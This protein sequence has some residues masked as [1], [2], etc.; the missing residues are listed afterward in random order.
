MLHS[1][2]T[3][4]A[5]S[6]AT[7]RLA[8]VWA[9]AAALQPALL[10]Q[11]ARGLAQVADAD[12]AIASYGAGARL[13]LVGAVPIEPAK[14]QQLASELAEQQHW[15]AVVVAK[16]GNA[17]S[18]ALGDPL[19]D[20]K[21]RLGKD[22]RAKTS[23]GRDSFDS[24][25]LISLEPKRV[26]LSLGKGYDDAGLSEGDMSLY[27]AARRALRDGQRIDD[28]IRD[29]VAAIDR[30]LAAAQ[31]F[32]WLI[33]GGAAL[34]FAGITGAAA[35]ARRRKRRRAI[36]R[37]EDWSKVLGEQQGALIELKRWGEILSKNPRYRGKTKEL[38]DS[39]VTDVQHIALIR[40]GI[41]EALDQAREL[42]YPKGSARILNAVTGWRYDKALEVMSRAKVRF[43]ADGDLARALRGEAIATGELQSIWDGAREV[44]REARSFDELIAEQG[45]RATRVDEV[46]KRIQKSTQVIQASIEVLRA[47]IDRFAS[48]LREFET[49]TANDPRCHVAAPRA[50]L[51]PSFEADYERTRA[52]A[53]PDPVLAMEGS[54]RAEQRIQKSEEVLEDLVQVVHDALPRLAEGVTAI[55][56][57]G[58]E[59]AWI[60]RRV[61]SVF[62]ACDARFVALSDSEVDI[63]AL[64]QL[65]IFDAISETFDE[66]GRAL[67]IARSRRD[68]GLP[69]L[70]NLRAELANERHLIA[71]KLGIEASQVLRERDADP[72]AYLTR[73]SEKLA[74]S[75]EA[76]GNGEVDEAFALVSGAHRETETARRILDDTRAALA[77]FEER[78]RA[79][80]AQLQ[81]VAGEDIASARPILASLQVYADAALRRD[82][83]EAESSLRTNITEASDHI[84]TATTH[85]EQAR[86]RHREARLLEADHDLDRAASFVELA[87]LRLREL[88]ERRTALTH[89]EDE[90]DR[91]AQTLRALV[92]DV[93]AARSDPAVARPTISKIDEAIA[94]FAA[95]AERKAS[96]RDPFARARELEAAR[97]LLHAARS[98]IDADHTMRAEARRSVELARELLRQARSRA[99]DAR[100]DAIPDS[101]R[102]EEAQRRLPE[103]ADR[104]D[105]LAAKLVEP[106]QDWVD[107]DA[108]ID[109]LHAEVFDL[110]ATLQREIEAGRIAMRDIE[111]AGDAV[112]DAAS[113]TETSFGHRLPGSPGRAAH[114]R[115]KELLER[116]RYAEASNMAQAAVDEARNAIAMAERSRASVPSRSTRGGFPFGR[117]GGIDVEGMVRDIFRQA[118]TEWSGH[119]RYRG[120]LELPRNVDFGTRS[121]HQPSAPAPS[122]RPSAPQRAPAD[123][124]DDSGFG[125][126]VEW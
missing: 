65:R 63:A 66:I 32:P 27:E 79:L 80:S 84:T 67:E 112:R 23:F 122:P 103:L 59:T 61:R 42:I 77:R 38:A 108:R 93:V 30:R 49:L 118:T 8:L 4:C 20:W 11:E 1:R 19:E 16:A 113:Y 36:V 57:H 99:E 15:V 90:N 55:S 91:N 114:V 69:A 82:G 81:S 51:L 60:D 107:L 62:E 78:S 75:V 33:G 96:D 126:S 13:I 117:G 85:V 98:G 39:I 6:N 86:A 125:P 83:G 92:Q 106:H 124:R 44:R 34:G 105:D 50:R 68:V 14:A 115:A 37:Y 119:R 9:L 48:A 53:L 70:D 2:C 110:E 64:Q 120:P 88:S 97:A 46:V 109:A 25:L 21:Q 41:L 89:K 45:S 76:L 40:G 116:G 100:R 10:A 74:T 18:A 56:G 94:T 71:E 29:T 43:D 102:I 31:R 73:A 35:M 22:L 87:R 111:R 58:I 5:G 28:A 104:L 47:R 24:I 95:V 7:V 3:A 54:S 17:L 26:A 12:A 72:D 121:R 52:I 123:S 101:S